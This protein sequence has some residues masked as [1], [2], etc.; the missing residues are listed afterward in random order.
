LF[1][2]RTVCSHSS[3]PTRS[4]APGLIPRALTAWPGPF[5]EDPPTDRTS[6]SRPT[7]RASPSKR[8]AWRHTTW[9][10]ATPASL[11]GP[12]GAMASKLTGSPSPKGRVE[13]ALRARENAVTQSR[14][15]PGTPLAPQRLSRCGLLVPRS[16]H[17]PTKR[18]PR[19]GA[20]SSSVR[21]KKGTLTRPP[22][23]FTKRA[24]YV[25]HFLVST[26]SQLLRP[27]LPRRRPRR[28]T[29]HIPARHVGPTTDTT[30]R[31]RRAGGLLVRS[32]RG[33]RCDAAPPLKH[34]PTASQRS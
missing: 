11:E 10:A 24:E 16:P 22:P 34:Y 18:A 31:T 4:G 17:P 27:Q 3:E 23:V 5:T 33:P 28:P 29:P 2:R 20:T 13:F 7:P 15:P 30:S 12:T 8:W 9:C 1:P 25:T 21:S 6:R 26:R 19:Q 14:A 32:V